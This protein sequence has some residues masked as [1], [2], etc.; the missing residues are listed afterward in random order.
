MRRLPGNLNAVARYRSVSRRYTFWSRRQPTTSTSV[1]EG[2]IVVSS[3]AAQSR[4][5]EPFDAPVGVEA[6]V[7]VADRYDFVV[8]IDTHARHHVLAIVTSAGRLVE[9]RQ[10]STSPAGLD[11]ALAWIT[12]HT[13][14]VVDHVLVSMESVGCYGAVFAG[15]L[16]EAGYRV[17]EAPTPRRGMDGKTDPLDARLAAQATLMMPIGRLRDRRADE[18]GQALQ[19]LTTSRDQLTGER[20]ATI[21]QLTALVRS[22]DLGEDARTKLKISQIRR[23]AG[24]RARQESLVARTARAEA[25]RMARKICDLD[26]Q[27]KANQAQIRD[28]VMIAAPDL[29]NLP[30]VGPIS[31]AI[32]LAAFSQPGRIRTEAGFAKL[33]GT[34]PIP[35]SSGNTSRHRLNRFG[36]RRLNRATHMIVINRLRIDPRTRDYHDRRIAQG[37]TPAEIRRCLKRYVT[38]QLFRVL[39]S[40]HQG[41][42]TL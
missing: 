41:L 10:F 28:L 5:V 2:N 21:N 23:I 17:T 38:R 8:G 25:V 11:R 20:A 34:C 37:K 29:L 35:A 31:A 27:I 24:W 33:A 9:S 14:T 1:K 40:T 3:V 36:D 30:G 16:A 13:S 18:T 39:K 15:R 32:V 26:T 22:H 6:E 7:T 12:R 42:D 19:I 4:G